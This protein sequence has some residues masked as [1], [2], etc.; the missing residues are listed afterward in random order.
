[1][2]LPP[3]AFTHQFARCNDLEGNNDHFE[4]EFL[5][6]IQGSNHYMIRIN[7]LKIS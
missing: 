4:I 5:N 2:K 6:Q 7:P 3:V 1:V